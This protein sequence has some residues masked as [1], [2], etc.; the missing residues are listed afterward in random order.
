MKISVVGG[1]N[2]GTQFAAHAAAKGH[3]VTIFTS[4][5]N[6]FSSRLTV[7]DADGTE[8]C[9]G[10][11]RAT[12]LPCEAFSLADVVFITTP[13][14]LADEIAEKLLPFVHEGMA[15]GLI[16][17]TGGME[18][19]FRGA[20]ECGAAIFGL[21]R[22]PSVARLIRYGDTVCAVGYRERL[23]LAAL[24]RDKTEKYCGLMS[25][26]FSMP[27]DALP[28]YL[29]VTM[30]PS[31]PILHTS[32]LRVLFSDYKDGKEYEKVPLFY[33][34]WDDETSELL[35]RCDDEVQRVCRAFKEIDLSSVRSLREH[36]ESRTPHELTEK[37]GSI[38]SFR[39]LASPAVRSGKGWIP[40]LSSRYFTADFP[41]GLAILQQIARFAGVPVPALNGVYGWYEQIV[42]A[43]KKF[44]YAEYAIGSRE[45]FLTFYLR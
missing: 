15:I 35:F 11:V 14:F 3:E 25:S 37:I 29:N 26:I 32:R 6:E 34:D 33:E 22:V 43:H 4:R 31:N 13:A 41:Y 18:C 7:V 20:L 28:N 10:D 44:S 45:E 36:Y 17:G 30:T 2:V 16:P 27:C 42:G 23:H 8:I 1:G 19:A 39:G 9:R 12:N 21:Q 24:P 5:P 40:D 38:R